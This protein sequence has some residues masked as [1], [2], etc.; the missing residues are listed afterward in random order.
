MGRCRFLCNALASQG[1]RR[2]VSRRQIRL[3]WESLFGKSVAL[4][5]PTLRGCKNEGITDGMHVGAAVGVTVIDGM[6][7]EVAVG[8]ADGVH[9]GVAVGVTELS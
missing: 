5:V 1:V 8:V 4:A 9:V 2:N 6:H 3:Q 7:V